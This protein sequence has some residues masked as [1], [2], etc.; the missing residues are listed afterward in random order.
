MDT[1]RK[2]APT[3]AL[4][5]M[6][7]DMYIFCAGRDMEEGEEAFISYGQKSNYELLLN[8]GFVLVEEGKIWGDMCAYDR[9]EWFI[10]VRTVLGY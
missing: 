8:Y 1:L 4:T 10:S 7:G 6:R 5:K 9:D 2:T 3:Y